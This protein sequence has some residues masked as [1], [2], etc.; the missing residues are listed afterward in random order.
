MWTS[1]AELQAIYHSEI[2]LEI[3]W[4]WDGCIEVRLGDKMNGFLAEKTVTPTAG[5]VPWVNT[6]SRLRKRTL[7]NILHGR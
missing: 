7:I 4:L 1:P 5:I 6:R 3:G 2:N